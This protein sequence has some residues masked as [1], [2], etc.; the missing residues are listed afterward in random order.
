M[1]QVVELAPYV[2]AGLPAGLKNYWYPVLQS[3]ELPADRPVGFKVLGEALVAWRD[4]QGRP[5]V[6]RDR[7]PHR[8]MR[9]S[10]GRV[11]AGELQCAL[12]G[13]RFDAAGSCTLI[14]WET[15]A[16]KALER[17]RIDAYPA[18][19][20][21]RY[22][23]A[24]IGDVAQFP[25]PPFEAE[26]PGSFPGPTSSSG[27]ACRRRYGRRTGCWRSTAATASTR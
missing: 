5:G 25:P 19:E 21:G 7:C 10:A 22:V 1:N 2:P 4:A 15:E 17:L 11:L 16:T 24:Y 26:V 27:S 23:W 6:V 18:A 3:E 12:H 13:L 8:S 14:P 20:L 9:L